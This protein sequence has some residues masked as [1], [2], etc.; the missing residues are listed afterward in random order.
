MSKCVYIF[1][2]TLCIYIYIYFFFSANR[3]I[4]ARGPNHLPI[5][6]EPGR[7]FLA[8]KAAWAWSSPLTS[9]QYR[10]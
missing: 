6:M 2:A 9:V 7:S 4:P 3:F 10:S 5:Q 8:I 1:W